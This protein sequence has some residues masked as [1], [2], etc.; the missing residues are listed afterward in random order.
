M[1][2]M[3]PHNI[4]ITSFLLSQKDMQE[5]SKKQADVGKKRK[6]LL[7][8]KPK[9]QAQL[10]IFSLCWIFMSKPSVSTL[11]TCRVGRQETITLCGTPIIETIAP[12]RNTNNQDDGLQKSKR[13]RWMEYRVSPW[14]FK[15]EERIKAIHSR[16]TVGP[17]LLAM[18]AVK[19]MCYRPEQHSIHL[20]LRCENW[21]EQNGNVPLHR[22]KTTLCDWVK[23]CGLTSRCILAVFHL[24]W[25]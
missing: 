1:V 15:E 13:R 24:S 21:I 4:R 3:P 19:I 25:A 7:R 17:D 10:R 11:P 8:N 14:H 5:A 20:P 22:F 6:R 2:T 9:R 16:L 12:T 23:S 18:I